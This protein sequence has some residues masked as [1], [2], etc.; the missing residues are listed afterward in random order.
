VQPV[1]GEA[2]VVATGSDVGAAVVVGGTGVAAVVV[3]AGGAVEAAVVAVVDGAVAAV[4]VAVVG[5]VVGDS[6]VDTSGTVPERLS[7]AKRINGYPSVNLSRSSAH[8]ITPSKL[9]EFINSIFACN[10]CKSSYPIHSPSLVT[11]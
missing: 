6:D 1:A 10:D 2:V 5:G 4:V 3:V 7:L 11:M 9:R 8:T